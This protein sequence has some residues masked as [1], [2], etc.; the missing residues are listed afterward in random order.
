[1]SKQTPG[2]SRRGTRWVVVVV[3]LVAFA[4]L[5]L[6][7]RQPDANAARYQGKTAQE[8]FNLMVA[9]RNGHSPQARKEQIRAIRELG[10]NSIPIVIDAFKRENGKTESL[11]Q[12]LWRK[13]PQ[14]VRRKISEP[15]SSRDLREVAR[16]VASGLQEE[17]RREVGRSVVP[18]L[19]RVFETAPGSERSY[20]LAGF[21]RDLEPDAE[22]RKRAPRCLPFAS[23]RI[24]QTLP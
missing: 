9:E 2:R 3:C 16:E 21:I 23:S 10:T 18:H 12:A 24:I 5:F 7:N 4:A 22:A 13:S 8:W 14:F 20:I 1:M 17:H 15:V 11:L 6:A 19:L